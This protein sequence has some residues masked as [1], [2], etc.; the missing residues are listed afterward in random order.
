[1]CANRHPLAGM[2]AN[3]I[4]QMCPDDVGHTLTSLVVELRTLIAF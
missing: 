3:H 1:M 2:D 4:A